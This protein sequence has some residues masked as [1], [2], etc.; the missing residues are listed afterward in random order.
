MLRLYLY[1]TLML[2]PL[3]RVTIV[4][5][6]IAASISPVASNINRMVDYCCLTVDDVNTTRSREK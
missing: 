1:V 4:Y 2:R 3:G 6:F 5:G